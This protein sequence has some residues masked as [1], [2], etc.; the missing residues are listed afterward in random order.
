M[1]VSA[2]ENKNNTFDF[3][4]RLTAFALRILGQV[5]QYINLDQISV[6]NSLLWLIDN[7]QMPDGSFSEFSDYQPVKLQV[8]K[9][10]VYCVCRARIKVTEGAR[11]SRLHFTRNLARRICQFY[12]FVTSL[13]NSTTF[14]SFLCYH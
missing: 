11:Y 10:D 12:L 6:C 4:V 2:N 5:N 14:Q 13:Q 8:W 9:L 1:I 7:C 3:F